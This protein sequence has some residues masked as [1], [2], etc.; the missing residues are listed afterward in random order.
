MVGLDRI[1]CPVDGSIWSQR[2]LRYGVSLAGWY[3]GTATALYVHRS[4]A[5]PALWPEYPFVLPAEAEGGPDEQRIT[6]CVRVTG[7]D[8]VPVLFRRGVVVPEILQ[9]AR[10][11]PA[12]LIVMGTHGAGAIEHLVLGSVTENVL[13]SAPCPV[14]TIPRPFGEADGA[15]SRPRFTSIICAIDFSSDSRR[16]LD[17]ALSLALEAGGRLVLVHAGHF[18]ARDQ[19]TAH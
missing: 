5:A 10:E 13:R 1:L 15:V 19:T 7:G 16:A 9:A 18:E 12:D 6:A 2:A 8:E 17:Y 14:L 4:P 11:M 3:R